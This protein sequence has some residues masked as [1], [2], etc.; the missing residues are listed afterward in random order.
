MADVDL[1]NLV[2]FDLETTGLEADCRIVQIAIVR[3]DRIYQSLVNPEMPIPPE[4]TAIHRITDEQ[5][6]NMPKFKDVADDVLA[7]IEGSVLS[8]FNIR[9]FDVPVLKRELA[10]CDR[11][12]PSFPILDMFELNQ[13]V[14]PR[15]LAWFFEHYTGEPMDQSEAHDAVYDCAC[16]RK[17]FLGMYE[18]HPELPTDLMELTSYSEPDRLPVANSGWLIW[19]PSQCE[20]SFNRGKYRGWALSDVKRKEPSYLEWLLRIDADAATKTMIQLFKTNRKEYVSLLKNEHPNRWEPTYL[21][22]RLAMDRKD[23]KRFSELLEIASSS[24]EPSIMFLAAA[25]AVLLK[26]PKAEALASEYLKADDPN[27]NIEKRKNFLI[28]NLNLD[29]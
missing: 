2:F 5:V 15:T 6:A 18:K 17:A 21:E 4:S 3:G 1:N 7:F 11:E 19:T 24:K 14:N 29:H 25:W 22:Y 20:P 26:D 13:K 28:Q 23:T 9:K 10:R 27:V 8:G 16:T 12:L